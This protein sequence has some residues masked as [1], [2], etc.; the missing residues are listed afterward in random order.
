[1]RWNLQ[2]AIIRLPLPLP[3][4]VQSWH[5]HHSPRT[6]TDLSQLCGFEESRGMVSVE[7]PVR[8]G[9]SNVSQSK[10]KR[11]YPAN[12]FRDDKPAGS[13]RRGFAVSATE[14]R[15]LLESW[16][17][18]PIRVV[19]EPSGTCPDCVPR[20]DAL[21]LQRRVPEQLLGAWH[22]GAGPLCY[23]L[24][25]LPC[26]DRQPKLAKTVQERK[27][28]E[29]VAGPAEHGNGNRP[30]TRGPVAGH[31]ASLQ[32]QCH[33]VAEC[34]VLGREMGPQGVRSPP[35][36]RNARSACR[37]GRVVLA[38]PTTSATSPLRSERCQPMEPCPSPS[39][40]RGQPACPE[41][42]PR[43][44]KFGRGSSRSRGEQKFV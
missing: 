12:D 18:M 9:F 11:R 36:I 6:I 43:A 27:A 4:S 33:P 35:F 2:P 44:T 41:G 26:V 24:Q 17:Q 40:Q 38:G 14:C 7:S 15:I 39:H 34:G 16:L 29:A 28:A 31:S 20:L 21:E 23:P 30:R 3:S 10:R 5:R 19:V 8:V 37:A 1:M 25:R 13:G 42:M 32:S 22:R